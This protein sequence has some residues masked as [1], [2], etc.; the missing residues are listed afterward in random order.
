MTET[1]NGEGAFASYILGELSEPR[2]Q[3]LEQGYFLDK[4]IFEDLLAT[5]NRLVDDYVRGRLALSRRERL[6]QY[7][8]SSERG[9]RKVRFATGFLKNI[10]S[11]IVPPEAA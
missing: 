4:Q 7:V 3:A 10:D 11:A 9:R 2:R 8:L 6:E 1:D 5:E